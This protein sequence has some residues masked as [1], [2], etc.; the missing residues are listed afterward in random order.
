MAGTSINEIKKARK[1]QSDRIA[2]ADRKLD[3]TVGVATDTAQKLAKINSELS[4]VQVQLK[5]AKAE[6]AK[7]AE[8]AGGED[9][10]LVQT[11]EQTG[12]TQAKEF[13]GIASRTDKLKEKAR[14]VKPSDSRITDGSDAA[15]V[16][17]KAGSEV[18]K[19]SSAAEKAVR[20][21]EAQRRQAEK[22]LKDAASLMRR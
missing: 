12:T 6:V 1:E 10:K 15:K 16:L 19:E 3:T 21:S 11:Q 14:A 17:E 20:D 22:K 5:G 13:Q 7:S 18:K 2:K 8:R 4:D 9:T